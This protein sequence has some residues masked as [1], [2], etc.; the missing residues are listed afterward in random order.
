MSIDRKSDLFQEQNHEE[1]EFEPSAHH[2]SAP[3]H[4]VFSIYTYTCIVI[5][6]LIGACYDLLK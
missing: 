4:E 5:I 6:F 2:P 3:A 1:L